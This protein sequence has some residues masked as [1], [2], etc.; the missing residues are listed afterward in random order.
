MLVRIVVALVLGAMSGVYL[1]K[2]WKSRSHCELGLATA[3]FLLAVMKAT[4]FDGVG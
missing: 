3:Y 2:A 1:F 4:G